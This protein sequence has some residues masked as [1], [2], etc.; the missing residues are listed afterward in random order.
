M[1]WEQAMAAALSW[2]HLYGIRYRVYGVRWSYGA[3]PWR[4]FVCR[5][6]GR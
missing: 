6:E 1:T 2:S 5:V 4:W 3:R